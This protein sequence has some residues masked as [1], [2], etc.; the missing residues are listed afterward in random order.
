[1][2]PHS[3]KGPRVF[4]LSQNVEG[5]KNRLISLFDS[6]KN[7]QEFRVSVF[8]TKKHWSMINKA[9][10][11]KNKEED[12]NTVDLCIIDTNFASRYQKRLLNYFPLLTIV[13]TDEVITEE[14]LRNHIN[15][16]PCMRV[17]SELTV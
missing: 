3:S 10:V 15:E 5:L 16:L 14:L 13:T 17:L 11:V 1:M 4:I 6:D 7:P 12:N 2:N 9:Q 8:D